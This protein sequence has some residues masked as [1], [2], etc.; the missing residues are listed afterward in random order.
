[1]DANNLGNNISLTNR[2]SQ[3]TGS[4]RF[5][6]L[7][8]GLIIIVIILV[9]LV[10]II[11]RNRQRAQQE[12]PL[13]ISSPVDAYNL[14]SNTFTVKNSDR[15]L[16]YTYSC[17]IYVQDWYYNYGKYKNIFVKGAPGASS[18]ITATMQ[19]TPG[20][21]LYPETNNLLVRVSTML[22]NNDQ[23]SV[24]NVP[25]QKW[26]HIGVVLNNRT[27]DVY[28]NGKLERSK[29]LSGVPILSDSNVIVGA[30]GGF[31]GKI[32]RFQYFTRALKPD[33]VFSIY[34]SGPY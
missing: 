17:W 27:V 33:E 28:V 22:N 8:V 15:G 18:D 3:T 2:I 13:L 9:V 30:N 25:L 29:V 10:V 4:N 5:L 11:Y 32:S 14:T 26:V 16:E 6:F 19:T 23:V 7:G 20:V 21:Y 34:Q 1:M 12:N 31:F 24:T